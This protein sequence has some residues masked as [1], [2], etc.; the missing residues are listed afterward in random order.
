MNQ[1]LIINCQEM[2]NLLT[3]NRQARQAGL[4]ARLQ[5]GDAQMTVVMSE[6]RV[7]ESG[8]PPAG[9]L[10]SPPKMPVTLRGDEGGRGGGRHQSG[11]V[12]GHV[13]GGARSNAPGS[14]AAVINRDA[15]RSD[16]TP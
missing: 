2:G 11:R 6:M 7:L 10:G 8:L 16:A 15:R 5:A 14:R 9:G 4:Q 12:G 3:P 1:Q 13:R